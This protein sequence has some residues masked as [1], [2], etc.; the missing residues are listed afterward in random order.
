MM[1]GLYLHYMNHYEKSYSMVMTSM[2]R[3]WLVNI[4]S[5]HDDVFIIY[6]FYYVESLLNIE[7][8]LK[9]QAE[10]FCQQTHETVSRISLSYNCISLQKKGSHISR[11]LIPQKRSPITKDLVSY[12][13][14]VTSLRHD[15]VYL[16]KQSPSFFGVGNI[17]TSC[18][19]LHSLYRLPIS[20]TNIYD[21][22]L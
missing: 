13:A 6:V 18:Y 20:L 14:Q 12:I 5:P 11:V 8:I 22:S 3:V 2:K 16:G 21:L 19:N 1:K 7:W 17:G 15:R 4:I 10:V 9:I